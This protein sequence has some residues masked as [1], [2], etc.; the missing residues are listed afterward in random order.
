MNNAQPISSQGIEKNSLKDRVYLVTGATGGLGKATSMALAKY[1]ATVVLTGRN[2]KKLDTIYD[3][4]KAAGYPTPAIIPFDLEQ[5]DENIY[6]QLINSI[7]NEFKRLDGVIHAACH[8]GVI[9][10]I[11]SQD[12]SE[13]QKSQQVNVNAAALLNKVSIPLLQ[14]AKHASIT[15]ISD[16]SA[17][18]SKAY[19]GAYGISKVAMESFSAMLADELEDS[20]VVC[21]VFIPGPCALPI[22][23]KTHP[24]ENSS[25]LATAD[26]LAER[27]MTLSITNSSGKTFSL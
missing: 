7:Y 4:I 20:S 15:F 16:S 12:S 22:R 2:E 3:Q 14:Q 5:K 21:N 27:I 17:R 9:G 24:G 1:G 10:P 23:K 6:H 26:Q 25:K 19:W 11:G 13:W 8:L 18:Q